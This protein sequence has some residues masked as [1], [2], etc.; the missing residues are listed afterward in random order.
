MQFASLT[1]IW[2]ALT[3]PMIVVMYLFKRKY[4]DTE[5]SSHLLWNRALK[6][7]EANRPWQKLRNNLLLFIQLLVASLLVFALMQ[8][9][10]WSEESR[11]SHVL[12]V[13]DRSASMMADYNGAAEEDSLVKLEKLKQRVMEWINNRENNQS[14]S[15]VAMGEHAEVLLSR[16]TEK[17][18]IE[19]ALM[20]IE[21]FYGKTAYKEAM[22][23]AA[24]LTRQDPNA[25]IRLLTDGQWV[26]TVD[27]LRFHVPVRVEKIAGGASDNISIT[28]FGVKKENSTNDDVSAAATLKNWGTQTMELDLSIYNGEE[29][30]AIQKEELQSG[31]QK[32]FF[33]NQLPVS[34]YYEL[35]IDASDD[36]KVDNHSYSFLAD[37]QTKKALLLSEGNVFLE[38]A[39]RLSGVSILK[40]QLNEQGSMVIPE[41]NFDF[42]VVDSVNTQL[43]KSV[44]W[45]EILNE[46][47]VW[48]ISYD[49]QENTA[50]ETN[51]EYTIK[52]HPIT[53]YIQFQD[54]HIAG[55]KVYK[56]FNWG[57][58]IISSKDIPLVYAG[59]VQ[60][61]PKILFTFDLH[62]SDLPL[63]SEFPVLVENIVNWLNS[64]QVHSLGHAM[65][66]E[67]MEIAIAPNTSNIKWNFVSQ[68]GTLNTADRIEGLVQNNQTTPKAPG[69]YQFIE[70][71][72]EGNQIQTRYLHVMMDPRESNLSYQPALEF[73]MANQDLMDS[74]HPN[75]VTDKVSA[76]LTPHSLIPW[77]IIILLGLTFVEWGVYQRGSSL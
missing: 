66:G 53:E 56:P 26:D 49:L 57:E 47:P 15:I 29:L 16:E 36:L 70:F 50:V 14:V 20:D 59:V 31:Q 28:Q 54:T 55:A 48:Y 73:S 17:T 32:T 68:N 23:L 75:G 69:L 51:S 72:Q 22:S 5:V 30:Y 74:Q 65:P 67:Q 43:L 27:G 13:I 18:R 34:D 40:T 24:A 25:E 8:P 62:H 46:K 4:I 41:S 52:D 64:G 21:I 6:D 19:E 58:A 39:L 38:K 76:G 1:S 63:R 44:E 7:L 12:F 60:G 33:F 10:I 61:Y 11:A 2:F 45:Q 35:V 9:F 37:D 3:L 42:V 71:D 77:I